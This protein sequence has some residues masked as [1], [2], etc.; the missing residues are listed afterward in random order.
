[1]KKNNSFKVTFYLGLI[2][3][4]MLVSI[5]TLIV[6]NVYRSLEP[7][8]RKDKVEIFIDNGEPEKEI[9]HDTVYVDKPRVK[10]NDT[11]KNVSTV[12]PKINPVVLEKTDTSVIV[13]SVK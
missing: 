10:I 9:I 2:I 6:F 13:D 5:I 3:I 11:P 4:I 7:K 8:L 1:M 12:K